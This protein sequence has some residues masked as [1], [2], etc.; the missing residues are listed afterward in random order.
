M[1]ELFGGVSTSALMDAA[2]A[3]DVVHSRQG[4][5]ISLPWPKVSSLLDGG[6]H[7]EL[8]YVVADWVS[9]S[10]TFQIAT[11]AAASGIPV[12]YLV[13]ARNRST[14]GTLLTTYAP[15]VPD[16]FH[17]VVLPYGWWH[18]PSL[19]DYTTQFIRAHPDS[20]SL[21]APKL[22]VI[23]SITQIV[24]SAEGNSCCLTEHR[25]RMFYNLIHHCYDIIDSH[26]CT[27]L[28]ESAISDGFLPR[29]AD[30][31]LLVDESESRYLLRIGS[32]YGP[33]PKS[34]HLTYSGLSFSEAS[35]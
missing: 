33:E 11:H 3:R 32:W 10:F 19:E 23:S 18:S 17:L 14:V 2:R 34:T 8:Y 16:W 15:P 21:P 31:M 30:M 7:A 29:S 26:N 27:I 12:L 13:A 5:R 1:T 25:S 6:L 24:N 22:I 4:Y 20:T 35:E 9:T 28:V